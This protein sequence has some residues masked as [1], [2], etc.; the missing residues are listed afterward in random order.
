M[1]GWL[2]GWVVGWLGGWV[3][4]WLGGWVVGSLV[5]WFV[6]WLVGWLDS[7]QK[8][9][10]ISWV[11]V[12]RLALGHTPMPAKRSVAPSHFYR[13]ITQGTSGA[14]SAQ[15][16]PLAKGKRVKQKGILHMRNQKRSSQPTPGFLDSHYNKLK[17]GEFSVDRL[18]VLLKRGA[19]SQ[20]A[21]FHG[22][23][24]SSLNC[25]IM[26]VGSAS[27]PFVETRATRMNTWSEEVTSSW[28]MT[29]P[30]LKAPDPG[31]S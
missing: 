17:M 13:M 18:A 9:T 12:V 30:E 1:V 2:G 8:C 25:R 5:R 20:G 14:R 26:R 10:C 6:G 22:L 4:G 3:V 21:S 29:S 15:D 24:C 28:F 19:Q 11:M 16:M 27:G 7:W 23:T 31:H